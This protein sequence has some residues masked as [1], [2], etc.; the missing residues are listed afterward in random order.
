MD[1]IELTKKLQEEY[2]YATQVITFVFSVLALLLSWKIYCVFNC[3]NIFDRLGFGI[4]I[5]H[6]C[7]YYVRNISAPGRKI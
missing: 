2:G 5:K 6:A 1:Y 4:G 3:K 7:C